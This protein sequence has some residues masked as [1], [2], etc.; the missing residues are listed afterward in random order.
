M[1]DEAFFIPDADGFRA[2]AYTRGPWTAEHQHGGPSAALLAGVLGRRAGG[3]GLHVARLTVEFLRP[4][5]IDRFVVREATLRPGKKVAIFGA[6]LWRGDE[7]IVRAAAVCI[8]EAPMDLAAPPARAPL[9]TPVEQSAPFQFPFFTGDLGYHRAM[10]S[11]VARGTFG[12]GAMTVW[13]RARIPI[14]AGEEI[15]PL[16]RVAVAADSGNGVSVALDLSRF[17]FLNPDLTIYLHRVPRGEWVCLDAVTTPEPHG[18]GL[19]DT[20]LFDEGGPIGRSLQSL[21]VQPRKGAG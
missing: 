8:R 5:A 2:T 3:A 10:E 4:I 14:V 18:V 17:T 12:A 6:S 1:H 13:M 20:A 15:T 7:E 16:Q 19:A 11:R 21:I 9:P